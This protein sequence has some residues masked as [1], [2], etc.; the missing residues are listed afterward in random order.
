MDKNKRVGLVAAALPALAYATFAAIPQDAEAAN[1][2]WFD[3]QFT[4]SGGCTDTDCSWWMSQQ[5]QDGNWGK[6]GS[7]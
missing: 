1:G 7:C 4:Q 3:G 5:C 6:C 2:C